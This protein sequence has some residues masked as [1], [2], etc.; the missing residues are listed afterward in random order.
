MSKPARP[1]YNNRELSW[2]D[3]NRRV[4]EEAL[5]PGLPPLERLKF[6]AIVSSNLD[7]FMMVRVGGLEML[8]ERGKN[9]PDLSGLT[10]EE[11]L[12]KVSE[13]VHAMVEEQYACFLDDL[14]PLLA[15]EGL[16]RIAVDKATPAVHEYLEQVFDH[17]LYPILS[18]LAVRDGEDFPAI[19]GLHLN[20]LVKLKPAPGAAGARP[21]KGR[22]KKAPDRYA[23]VPIPR[24][25]SRFITVPIEEGHNVALLEDVIAAFVEKLFPGEPI[26]ECRVFRITR[27][28]DMSVREDLAVDLMMRMKEVLDARKQSDCVRLELDAGTS[29]A[30]RAWLVKALQV[31]PDS[32]Y[33]IR[34][35]LDLAGWFGLA[36]A[37]GFDRLR[38]K[39][40]PPQPSP[41]APVGTPMFEILARRD[42]LLHHPYDSFDPV[43]RFIE[44]AANDPDVLAIKQILYRT[45]ENS[46]IIAALARAATRDKQVTAVV[47][48]KARFD[49]ARNISWA[50]ALEQAGV[51]VIYGIKGLKT[52]AKVCVVVRREAGGIRRYCH[53]G[54]GNY[55]EI[56]SRLYTDISYMTAREDYGADATAFFNMITGYSQPIRFRKIESA[57]IGLK[58]RLLDLIESEIL[59]SREGQPAAIRARFN[60]LTHPEVID[61]LYRASQAGVKIQLNVRGICCLRPGV[62]GLS[63]NIEVISII[64]RF[65][66]HSRIFYFH[67]G[68][69][70]L[71]FISSADWMQR[72]LDKRVELLVPVADPESRDRLVHILDI[73]FQD[74]A[75]ARVQ[76]ADGVYRRRTPGK[77]KT[78]LRSQARFYEEACDAARLQQKA[79]EDLFVPER[80]ATLTQG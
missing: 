73:A 19:P 36:R 14:T 67:Q 47:E 32:V 23:V 58:D 5:D 2:I 33:D 18:P 68:G 55:N 57:P 35:P 3:F 17:D 38:D 42:L 46:P 15:G 41:L 53:F 11:Q 50:Q 71:V 61:A 9:E 37:T 25:L 4:L 64:D 1:V 26:A 40:W 70:P 56:T 62:P 45:S 69:D 24:K 12:A 29:A 79:G 59:R 77:K 27:N 60:S 34:G 80:P 28:A 31:R 10:T 75:K 43:V 30:L 66:E 39:P 7:E 52:H 22:A 65:L 51:Q 72:N 78:V 21:G 63:D 44:E 76:Q 16:H 8:L 6:L 13:L 49:E 48:L 54:T 20:L 74:T